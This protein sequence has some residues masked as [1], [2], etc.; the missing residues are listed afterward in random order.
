M[1][2]AGRT[3]LGTQK[4]RPICGGKFLYIRKFISAYTKKD[5][6]ICENLRPCARKKFA[7]R[8]AKNRRAH[9]GKFLCARKYFFVRTEILLPAHRSQP[10]QA[11]TKVTPATETKSKYHRKPAEGTAG[12]KSAVIAGGK[13]PITFIIFA[14]Y[15]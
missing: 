9:A 3:L 13:A 15:E 11:E 7:V 4:M 10:T 6:R 12:A 8:E 5:F 2:R 14:K 1:D